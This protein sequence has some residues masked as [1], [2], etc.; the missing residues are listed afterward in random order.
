M[1]G[2]GMPDSAS[3]RKPTVYSVAVHRRLSSK[4]RE[5]QHVENRHDPFESLA[6]YASFPNLEAVDR[7]EL[8]VVPSVVEEEDENE[9][10]DD[11]L[12]ERDLR[13]VVHREL[14]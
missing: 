10:G 7:V 14:P 2:T 9:E 4:G 11:T 5:P 3:G 12:E 6:R 13:R 8:V 1:K